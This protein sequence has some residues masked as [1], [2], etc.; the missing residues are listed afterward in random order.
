MA[1]NDSKMIHIYFNSNLLWISF[2]RTLRVAACLKNF[3]ARK[4][5]KNVSA[6]KKT[7]ESSKVK[8]LG[9]RFCKQNVEPT[10]AKVSK[11]FLTGSLY[12]SVHQLRPI[13]QDF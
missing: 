8:F 11:V 4:N 5:F 6:I 2:R 7:R 13:G 3:M 1:L 10:T 12:G 9:Q